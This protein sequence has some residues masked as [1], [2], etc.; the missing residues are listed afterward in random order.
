VPIS[1]SQPLRVLLVEDNPADA[2]LVE[3]LLR[4]TS[5]TEISLV[6][7]GR[8]NQALGYLQQEGFNAVL[9]DLSLPDSAGLA[10]FVTARDAAPD[11]PIVVLTG[12]LDEDVAMKAVREGAQ[13]YLVKGQVS[14][15]V[16]YHSIRYAI[17]RH[18]IDGELRKS[19]ARYRN[20]VDGSIQGI[21]I[22]VHGI[23]RLANP[24]LARLLN[25]DSVEEVTG[26]SI[27][28]YIALDDRA[29]VEDY[30]R[31]RLEGRP[32]PDRYELRIVQRGGRLIWLDCIATAITWGGERAILATVVDVSERKRAQEALRGSEERF[33]QLAENI[34]EAFVVFELPANKPL[35]VSPVWEEM[36][37][38][39]V[40]ELF[41]DPSLWFTVI[42][43][44]DQAQVRASQEAMERGEPVAHTCRV[45]RADGTI[46]WVRAR[47]FPVF[48]DTGRAYRVAGLIEDIT[49]ARR[50]EEQF[51]QAQRM[52][53]VGRLA[54]GVAHDFNNLL[55]AILGYTELVLN[56]LGQSHPLSPDV[57]EIRRAGQSAAQLTRQLLAFSRRQ[58]LQPKVL[59]LNQIL[60]R[61]ESLLNRLIGED[62]SLR[63]S[64]TTP[65]AR[66]YADPG[67]VE[68]VIVNLVINARDA[69]PQ[70]GQLLIETRDVELDESYA[71][72][73]TGVVA[74]LYVMLAVSDTGNGMDEET[75]KRLFE[76]F[77][78]TKEQ[79][80]GTGL[81]LATV[82]G[83]VK[84]SGGSV[85]VYSE[86][87]RGTTFK[88]YL[89]A[90]SAFGGDDS[91]ETATTPR[92]LSGTETILVVE[93]QAE[94]RGVIRETLRRNGYT[95]LEATSGVEAIELSSAH[96]GPIDLLFTDVV[97]PGLSGRR[98][99]QRVT[100]ERSNVRVLYTSGYTD[101]A[102][103]QHG[104]LEPGLAFLQKPCTAEALL[105]KIRDV[106]DAP[107]APVI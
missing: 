70:G 2:Q 28:Q 81:G 19:E 68:Q 82:Y 14:G 25:I 15:Q 39:P 102:I 49:E 94:V 107:Q 20:L 67:Q 27:W 37:G 89:P 40:S 62:V 33:R 104:V 54:G 51:R 36:W 77:F 86:V 29:M 21:L 5:A 90:V 84:Q 53:A 71:R 56:G 65:L 59:D 11:A 43:R 23:I 52:E 106:L 32:V 76:P 97:M 4:E 75:Q 30:M 13:D 61:V 74:G 50:T 101:E 34:K 6:R 48:D 98:V 3:E 91:A 42:H 35:Y 38:R 55:M 47:M 99:A 10:T 100:A 66:V 96:R 16:L 93:D 58:I 12:L 44:E 79:G 88:I 78:T 41:A 72:Q 26:A 18:R 92:V 57:E 24:A 83:I 22:H 95:V 103:V 45:V 46:R 85:W 64:L 7:A 87:G 60:E 17:E 80:K 8:L 31:A 1:R 63:T 105:H 9:L 73:H 69:M